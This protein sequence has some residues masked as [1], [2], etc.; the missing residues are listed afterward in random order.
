MK[1][2]TVGAKTTGVEG[3]RTDGSSSRKTWTRTETLSACCPTQRRHSRGE[4]NWFSRL[5]LGSSSKSR[6]THPSSLTWSRS[7]DPRL[8]SSCR[9]KKRSRPA[10]Q[11]TVWPQVLMLTCRRIHTVFAGHWWLWNRP[12]VCWMESAPATSAGDKLKIQVIGAHLNSFK[13]SS[14][15]W[16][17]SFYHLCPYMGPM[18]PKMD[19]P[20]NVPI[21]NSNFDKLQECPFRLF[22]WGP[23]KS[24]GALI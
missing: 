14:L 17:F 21:T 18:Q 8:R 19:S 20:V 23:C 6:W 22:T 5:E 11:P 2:S 4:E 9:R 7:W 15:A 1:S 16:C 12:K 24:G 3:S 13:T 10:R